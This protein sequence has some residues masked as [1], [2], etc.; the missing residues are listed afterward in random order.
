MFLIIFLVYLLVV[1]RRKYNYSLLN[2]NDQVKIFINRYKINIE[3]V[4][5]KYL[6]SV[7]AFINSFILSLTS[8]IIFRIDNVLLSICVSFIIIFSL[9]FILFEIAGRYFKRLEGKVKE[10]KVINKKNKK[11]KKIKSKKKEVE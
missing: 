5:Y 7:I 1:N 9:I 10:V 2:E 8:A 3:K 6:L 11:N 4:N